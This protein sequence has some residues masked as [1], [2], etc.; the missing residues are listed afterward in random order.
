MFDKDP[1]DPDRDRIRWGYDPA[2]GPGTG[3]GANDWYCERLWSI[4]CVS[5]PGR[6][7]AEYQKDLAKDLD[8]AKQWRCKREKFIA[9][10]KARLVNGKFNKESKRSA[11]KKSVSVRKRKFNRSKLIKPDNIFWPMSRYRKKFGS[12]DLPKN[13]KLKHVRAKVNGIKGVVVPGDDGDGPYKLR[14]SEGVEIQKDDEEDVG[15]SGGE[16]ELADC[17]VIV[18]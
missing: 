13:K 15:S 14:S 11:G 18:L 17:K 8:K 2:S 3:E 7:R 10:L 16:D 9:K 6:R 1:L 5:V 4:E 12:P